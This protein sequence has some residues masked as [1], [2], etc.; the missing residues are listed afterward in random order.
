MQL[1]I[2]DSSGRYTKTFEIFIKLPTGTFTPL[3]VRH[4]MT[5]AELKS[6]IEF[7]SG[8]PSDLMLL[9]FGNNGVLT[10]GT[11]LGQLCFIPGTRLPVKILYGFEKLVLSAYSGDSKGVLQDIDAHHDIDIKTKRQSL[12][13][14]LASHRGY[15]YL[16]DKLLSAGAKPDA[17]TPSGRTALHAACAMGNIGCVDSLL[18]HNAALDIKDSHGR[19]PAQVA[20]KCGQ[21]DAERRILLFQRVRNQQKRETQRLNQSWPRS[22]RFPVSKLAQSTS[23][24]LALQDLMISP[25]PTLKITPWKCKSA[26]PPWT[27]SQAVPKTP[28][29]SS[30]SSSSSSE[31]GAET[32]GKSDEEVVNEDTNYSDR[33]QLNPTPRD[34]PHHIRFSSDITIHSDQK[35]K[36]PVPPATSISTDYTVQGMTNAY[37]QRQSVI[38][39]PTT[40]ILKKPLRPTSAMSDSAILHRHRQ[41][42]IRQKHNQTMLPTF[43]LTPSEVTMTSSADNDADEENVA[44]DDIQLPPKVRDEVDRMRTLVD[45][46][47]EYPKV[48]V[49]KIYGN[50]RVRVGSARRRATPEDNQKAYRLWVASKSQDA[51][52]RRLVNKV[53]KMLDEA[54][55][56]T[57]MEQL[58]APT[59]A[60]TKK[61]N[62]TSFEEWAKKKSAETR[63]LKA[64]QEKEQAGKE[65]ATTEKEADLAERVKAIDQWV[66]KKLEIEKEKHMQERQTAKQRE[67]IKTERQLKAE[68][69]FQNWSMQKHWQELEKWEKRPH[70]VS[71]RRTPQVRSQNSS[72]RQK[73]N[74]KFRARSM[75]QPNARRIPCSF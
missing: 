18:Q 64:Q 63:K 33:S 53:S 22:S 55:G 20:F 26:K 47:V 39:K 31:S 1:G 48:D 32:N 62:G 46:P 51:R 14:F 37:K 75:S 13:L 68:S 12:A 9:S 56:R 42:Q 10:D 45:M 17:Q 65:K 21:Q 29:S 43:E 58:I 6:V 59:V 3:N 67:A 8:I 19:T 27:L 34:V 66:N 4:D 60:E 70:T 44:A 52:D 11:T 23:P 69:A 73:S 50:Q 71:G 40:G 35:K 72:S 38:G 36:F 57:P 7:S 25:G 61:E 54:F 28:R 41:A 30:S 74:T 2:R 15:F 16:V 49:A 24:T 5:I